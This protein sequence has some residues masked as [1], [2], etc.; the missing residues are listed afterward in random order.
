MSENNMDKDQAS[1]PR[2]ASAIRRF[3]PLIIVGWIAITVLVTVAVPPLEVVERDHSVSLSPPDA[4]SVKAMTRMG[5]LFQESN[6][7]SVAVIVLEGEEPLGDDAHKYYDSLVSQLKQDPDHIQHVQDF[8]GDPLTAGAAQSA[9][10]KAAYV[11]LNLHGRFGQAA[12]NESVQAVQDVVKNTQAPPGITTYVTGP[13]AIVADM[14]QSGNRTVILITLVS[15]GVIFLMLLLLYRSLI[16]VV[17]LLFTV[18]IELQVAR[19][20]V[21]FLG[22][23]GL[24][25]LTT[26]VVNLLVSVGIAAGTDYAIFFTGRYQE[27]RQSGEDRESAYY[28][29]YRSVAKVVLASGLTIAGAIAC[30]SFTRLPYFQP[31]GVPGAVGILVAVAVA[32][33]LVPACIAAGSRFG[34]FDPKRPVVTR[35]WRR[36]GTAV[37]RWPAPILLATLAVALIGLLTLPGYNPSYSDQKYIPQDIPANQGFAAASRHFPES[38]MTT[39]DLLLV[40]ADHDMRNPTDLLILNKLAKAVFAVPGIANVQS[41]TRPEGTQIEHSSIPFMLSMSNASQRL[42]LPFQKERMEDLVKQADDMS[43]TISLMQR[44]YE[45]MQQ[46]VGTTHRMVGTTHELQSDMRELRDHMAD[47]DDFW[48]PLRNYLYWEPHCFD[49]PMCWSIRSIFDGLDGIDEVT[50]KMQGLVKELDQLD[51]LMPQMLLQFPQMI[52]TMQSTRT[53]MLTMHSTMSGLFTQMDESSDNATAMGKAFD[54]SNNDDSFYLPPDVLENKDFQRIMKIFLSPDGKAAR[55]LITQR[56]DPATPEGISRVEPLRI[57]A[58]EALKGTPLESSKLYLAGTAAGVKDL[59]DG[60]KIDLL[61]AGVTA[62]A[63]IF[64]IM[65]LMTRSFIAALVIVGTVALSLGASFGLSVLVWQYILGIQ[66]NWVVL[67]MSVIVLLAVGSDYNL[68]LVSRMKE[69]IH[70]GINTG[71]VRAMAGTGKVVTAAGLVFAA[72][73]ASMIVSDLLTI[74]QVGTTIGLGLLFDTLVVRAFM[75]PSIAAL[76]GRWFW[77]PQQVRPRPASTMLRPSGPRPLVRNLLLRD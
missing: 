20:F 67:A 66:I 17:I 68:L 13:A 15:V 3:S 12:A 65:V 18:G 36:I 27:A 48:R 23:H 21:A 74:G 45:L 76:L 54:A 71:I 51:L 34:I 7:E 6:S 33:T 35:R 50:D 75:T 26:Y 2:L 72:T 9:D 31:L 57:A 69:E 55:M 19:G 49:I 16:T 39:P 37:V 8:W 44:M 11:Q 42:S 22:L 70:A 73:M 52:A 63:L 43:K 5:Q 38:K 4:P 32:L 29:T 53:M 56:S 77:W 40:E 30:L 60:S 58:E 28:T 62:L 64:L 14:G 59:V 1:R 41:I 24:V 47:F 61:I 46:M 10:G 25:G